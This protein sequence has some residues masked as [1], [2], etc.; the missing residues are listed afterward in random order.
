MFRKQILTMLS[1]V[2]GSPLS[3]NIVD[4]S[5]V[6]SVSRPTEPALVDTVNYVS[7]N[8]KDQTERIDLSQCQVR[9]IG[10]SVI[11]S[12][13]YIVHWLKCNGTSNDFQFIAQKILRLS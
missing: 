10:Q 3:V 9:V 2:T 12:D 8:K 6:M 4:G 7:V 1:R 11:L 13:I 5:D